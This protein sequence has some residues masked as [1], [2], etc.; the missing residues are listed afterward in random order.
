MSQDP[1]AFADLEQGRITHIDFSLHVDFAGQ[2]IRGVADYSVD[3][4]LA[5]SFFLDTRDIKIQTVRDETGELAWSLDQEDPVLG[6]RGYRAL[7]PVGQLDGGHILYAASPRWYRRLRPIVLAALAL[8]GFLWPGWWLW[9]TI[10]LIIAWRHPPVLQAAQ[11]LDSRRQ[12]LA[13]VTLILF[14]VVFMPVPLLD[15]F[16]LL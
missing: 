10:L 15:V 1:H 13:L 6:Q 3:R 14:L 11:A 8:F 4:G 2:T 7:I 16:V 12:T 5:G 9:F